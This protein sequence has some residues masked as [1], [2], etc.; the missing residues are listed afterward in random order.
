[1]TAGQKL[2]VCQKAEFSPWG[3]KNCG[4]KLE[5]SEEAGLE[6]TD[7]QTRRLSEGLTYRVWGSQNPTIWEQKGSLEAAAASPLSPRGAGLS[8]CPEE[9]SPASPLNATL[10]PGTAQGKGLKQRTVSSVVRPEAFMQG[11]QWRIPAGPWGSQ[12]GPTSH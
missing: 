12:I 6:A 5:M 11:Q 2:S 4:G 1:M 9:E 3:F 7:L 10:R 8:W